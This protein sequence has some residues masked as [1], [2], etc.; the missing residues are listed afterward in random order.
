MGRG[1]HPDGDRA[2]GVAAGGGFHRN[3]SHCLAPAQREDDFTTAR[4]RRFLKTAF[5]AGIIAG[6]VDRI[7]KYDAPVRVF[8][9]GSRADRKTQLTRIVGDIAAKIKHLDIAMTET[10][11]AANVLVGRVRDCD[12]YRTIT[13][14]R[15]TGART[16]PG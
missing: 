16:R 7:R 8:A 3:P 15:R 9:D 14:L 13:T 4:S 5:G 10:S 6:R 1:G 2:R 11:E 12:L